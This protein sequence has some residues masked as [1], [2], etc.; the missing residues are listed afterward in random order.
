MNLIFKKKSSWT[1]GSDVLNL[2]ILDVSFE[3]SYSAAHQ[4]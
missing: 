3:A 1:T 2:L 4:L